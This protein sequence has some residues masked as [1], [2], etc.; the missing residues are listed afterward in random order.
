MFQ[1][2]SQ[3]AQHQHSTHKEQ[4]IVGKTAI[5]GETFSKSFSSYIICTWCSFDKQHSLELLKG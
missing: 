1:S 4:R 2:A 5:Y 3:E